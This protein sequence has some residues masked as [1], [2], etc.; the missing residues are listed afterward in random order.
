MQFRA[1]IDVHH[2]PLADIGEITPNVVG[3]DGM[4][5]DVK[6]ERGREHD[7]STN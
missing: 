1:G 7:A 6:T 3:M 5:K 2:L 4:K